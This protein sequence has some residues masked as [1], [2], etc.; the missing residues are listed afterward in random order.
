MLPV[1]HGPAFSAARPT[2]APLRLSSTVP[3]TKLQLLMVDEGFLWLWTDDRD[4]N[5]AVEKHIC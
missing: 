5:P 1:P 4:D 3:A 2:H